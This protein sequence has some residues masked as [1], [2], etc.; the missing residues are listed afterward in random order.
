MCELIM[1]GYLLYKFLLL[2]NGIFFKRYRS[3]YLC[4]KFVFEREGEKSLDGCLFGFLFGVY[5]KYYEEGVE[6]FVYLFL[7]WNVV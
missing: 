7:C 6:F 3:M 2:K 5:N 1:I 4:E